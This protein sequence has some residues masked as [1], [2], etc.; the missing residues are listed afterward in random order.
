MFSIFIVIDN[1]LDVIFILKEFSSSLVMITFYDSG[2]TTIAGAY[3]LHGGKDW[4]IIFEAL[5]IKKK[6]NLIYAKLQHHAL[7]DET[8][9]E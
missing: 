5:D 2:A 3:Y 4:E 7:S 9:D 6:Y 8:R 1:V